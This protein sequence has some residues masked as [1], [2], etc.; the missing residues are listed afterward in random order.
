MAAPLIVI[1]LQPWSLEEIFEPNIR[2][3]LKDLGEFAIHRGQAVCRPTA[4]NPTFP[5]WPF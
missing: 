1:D 4:S 5:T 2:A 3:R